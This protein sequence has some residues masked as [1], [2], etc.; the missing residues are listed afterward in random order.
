VEFGF[1]F[2]DWLGKPAWMWLAFIAIVVTLLVF[3]LGVLHR[4]NHE[5]EVR[6][7]LLM[8]AG[9]IGLGLAFGAGLFNALSERGGAGAAVKDVFLLSEGNPV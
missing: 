3:D 6:E 2:V 5:I 1:L 9:Y 4:D 8:S 7:S